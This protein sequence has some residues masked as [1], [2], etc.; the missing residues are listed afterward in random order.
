MHLLYSSLTSRLANLSQADGK[1]P[2]RHTETDGMGRVFVVIPRV[3]GTAFKV[4]ACSFKLKKDGRYQQ[5]DR[6][7]RDAWLFGPSA[8]NHES[9]SRIA[10]V[11]PATPGQSPDSSQH[12]TPSCVMDGPLSMQWHFQ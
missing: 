12:W 1:V 9:R 4:M 8:K 10:A 6:A 2:I 3:L 7:S 5:A 11:S